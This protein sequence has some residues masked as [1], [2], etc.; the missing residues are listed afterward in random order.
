M[1]GV[2]L[3]LSMNVPFETSIGERRP[4][5]RCGVMTPKRTPK[6]DDARGH[7]DM[8]GASPAALQDFRG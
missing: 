7:D 5:R 3:G 1:R 4:D 2:R 8:E 6:P